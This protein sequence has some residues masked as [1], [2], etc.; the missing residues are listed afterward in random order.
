MRR[1]LLVLPVAVMVGVDSVTLYYRSV[2]GMLAAE[3]MLFDE[4]GKV[5]RATAHYST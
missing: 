5:A 4:N 3:V 2:K 1:L